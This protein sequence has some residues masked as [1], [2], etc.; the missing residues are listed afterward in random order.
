MGHIPYIRPWYMGYIKPWAYIWGQ[1][2]GE[3]GDYKWGNNKI[4][5]CMDL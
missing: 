5:N 1:G 2:G 3:G 4:K